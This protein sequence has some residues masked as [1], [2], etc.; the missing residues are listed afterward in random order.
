[1][2]QDTPEDEADHVIAE[3]EEALDRLGELRITA[4]STDAEA[5]RLHARALLA[6]RSKGYTSREE[7]DAYATLESVD[8]REAADICERSYRDTL[9]Y[10]RTLQSRLDLI[11]TQIVSR[12]DIRV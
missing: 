8:A 3:M 5:K 4:A 7:R 2:T 10:I 11:R 12:R 9:T 1:M 6:A